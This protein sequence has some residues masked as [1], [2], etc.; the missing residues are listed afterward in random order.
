MGK[1]FLILQL[2]PEDEAADGEFAA[3]LEKGGISA[4][5]VHR[6]RLDQDPLPPDLDLDAYAGV[7]VGGGPGCVSDD[8]AT[9]DPAEARI[10]AAI[11]ALMPRITAEDIPFMGCCYGISILAHHLGT[12]VSKRRWGEPIGPVGVVKTEAGERDPLLDGLPSQFTALVGHKEAT[13][14]L[15]NGCAHLL[16]SETC[17][18]QMIRYGQNVYATQFHPEADGTIFADRIRIYSGHGYFQADEAAKL[19]ETALAAKTDE[20]PR[21]LSRFFARYGA[22]R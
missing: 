1:P 7:V 21:L 9:R 22:A 16:A 11:M 19:T 15:P 5:D 17:P 10:E 4:Q 20:A 8:P 2:R 6:V 18:F 12:E 14:A 13:Q 3:F